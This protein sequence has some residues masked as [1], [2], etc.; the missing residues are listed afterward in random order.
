M[1]FLQQLFGPPSVE[2]LQAE[3]DVDGLSQTLGRHVA[4]CQASIEAL[5]EVGD[6]RAAETLIDF[7]RSQTTR[8]AALTALGR[9]GGQAAQEELLRALRYK[10]LPQTAAES[11]ALIGKPAVAPLI[12]L[13]SLDDLEV[14][15]AAAG[16]LGQIGAPAV[17]PL[18]AALDDCTE[19]VQQ[20]IV[21]SL[22]QAGAEQAV[23]PIIDLLR[24]KEEDQEDQQEEEE[25][26]DKHEHESDEVR[27][28]A[29]KA[30]AELG[31]ERAIDPLIRLLAQG[32]KVD[33][34]LEE[35]IM[36]ALET[37]TG[38]RFET[39]QAW[40]EWW[41]TQTDGPR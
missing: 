23:A 41:N 4:A 22:G 28:I 30:L 18:I 19:D 40:R 1:S 38:Q 25:K 3:G 2:Q 33:D 36:E 35:S 17:E 5:G 39:P 21:W 27:R 11:L 24:Y 31:D 13:L 37:L 8:E 20:S 12:D 7:F 32:E 14:R 29:I 26:E 10:E 34:D 6:E 9:I 16:A 15:W